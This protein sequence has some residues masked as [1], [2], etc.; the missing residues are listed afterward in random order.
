MGIFE[1]LQKVGRLAARQPAAL[2]RSD[3]RAL[4]FD[5]LLGLQNVPFRHLDIVGQG[6]EP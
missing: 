1:Q 2:Q 3:T 6:H 4:A 5:V